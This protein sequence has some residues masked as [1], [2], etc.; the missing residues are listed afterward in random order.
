M[1]LFSLVGFVTAIFMGY[2][3]L[4]LKLYVLRI[5]RRKKR[6]IA[7]GI[8]SV[9]SLSAGILLDIFAVKDTAQLIYDI[10]FPV[11]VS[12]VVFLTAPKD[13]KRYE[14]IKRIKSHPEVKREG[15]IFCVFTLSYI[16]VPVLGLFIYTAVSGNSEF[17]IP[18]D[19]TDTAF[20]IFFLYVILFIFVTVLLTK[21]FRKY[22]REETLKMAEETRRFDDGGVSSNTDKN[23]N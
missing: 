11:V 21:S 22:Y 10:A 9:I 13:K 19:K 4:E 8:A 2:F 12:L 3:A 7:F 14:F 15:I 16:L 5:E 6:L 1:P 23:D 17:Y 18:P 20:G